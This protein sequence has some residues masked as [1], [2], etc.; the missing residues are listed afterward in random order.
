M[1]RKKTTI[2]T[3]AAPLLVVLLAGCGT[4]GLDGKIGN[5]DNVSVWPSAD[6]RGSQPIGELTTLAPVTVEC[7]TPGQVD[8]N[9]MGYGATYKISYDGGEGYIDAGTSVMSDKGEVAPGMVPQC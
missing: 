8:A 3:A 4:S 1:E 9:G 6:A 7:Y 2:A 5:Y